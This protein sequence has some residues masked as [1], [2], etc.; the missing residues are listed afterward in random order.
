MNHRSEL[1][2]NFLFLFR[3]A[4]AGLFSLPPVMPISPFSQESPPGLEKVMWRFKKT[5]GVCSKSPKIPPADIKHF[6]KQ[7]GLNQQELGQLCGVGQ[8]S[9]GRWESGGASPHGATL[10]LLQGLLDGT[11]NL[12][13]LTSAEVSRLDEIVIR[14]GFETRESLLGACLLE[15]LKQRGIAPVFEFRNVEKPP[16]PVEAP[17]S[18]EDSGWS[19]SRGKI[20]PQDIRSYRQRHG[21]TLKAMGEFCGVSAEAIQQWETGREFSASS[22]ILLHELLDGARNLTPL[23]PAELRL[24]DEIVERGGFKTRKAFLGFCLLE[25]LKS[26]EATPASK[27][28]LT[29]ESS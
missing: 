9:V 17:S 21:L 10:V 18:R 27:H 16:L 6:R 13:S 23:T 1:A 25:I 2:V 22:A 19:G 26:N 11:R 3:T 24:L 12:T 7:N 8:S 28:R 5:I 4:S 15:L 29:G 20:K 14:G